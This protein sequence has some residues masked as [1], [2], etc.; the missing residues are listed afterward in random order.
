[1]CPSLERYNKHVK[2][3]IVISTVDLNLPPPSSFGNTMAYLKYHYTF[4]CI[5]KASLLDTWKERETLPVTPN[6][7]LE[8][9]NDVQPHIQTRPGGDGFLWQG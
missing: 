5:E 4:M 8:K 6:M 2:G 3:R 9:A 1:M 7:W